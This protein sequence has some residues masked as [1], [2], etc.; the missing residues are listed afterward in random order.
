MSALPEYLQ[1]LLRPDAYPHPVDS[2]ELIETHVSWVLLTGEFAYKI[3]RPVHYGFIDLR[4]PERRAFLCQE[5]LRL[6]RRFAPD[7]YLDVRPICVFDGAA[8]LTGRGQVVEQAVRMRQF[9]RADE[10]DRLLEGD[11]IVPAELAVFGVELARLHAGLPVTGAD[12]NPG[13]ASAVRAR[14]LDNAAEC[15]RAEQP[16]GGPPGWLSDLERRLLEELN[17][18]QA[19]LGRRLLAGRVRECHGDLHARNIVRLGGH[20]RAFDCLEFDPAL[21]WLDVADEIAFL[22]ADLDAR[23]R[24]QHAQAFLGGYLE[25]S[26]DHEACTLLPLFKVHRALVRAKVAALAGNPQ[27]SAAYLECVRRCLTAPLP[28]LVLMCGLSGA[29]KSWLAQGLAAPLSAVLLRSD[30]ERRRLA[31]SG[32]LAAG[33]PGIATGHYAPEVTAQVYRH[34]LK[35]ARECLSGGFTTIVDAT[36]RQRADRL[37]FRD[38]ATSLGVNSCV[39]HC[40]APREVLEARIRERRR[41]ND[42]PSE[43]DLSVLA[44]QEAHFET[45]QAG[46]AGAVLSADTADSASVETLL[47]EIGALPRP[48]VSDPDHC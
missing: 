25:A 12:Q 13:W 37:A 17:R 35:C 7:L 46:E 30:V 38:L 2:M 10:L 27:G 31:A 22:L 18:A 47:Q 41:R 33:D 20:L 5:E 48:Q 14:V 45:P 21:R 9:T 6:N 32:T 40:R 42:D 11:R 43:A 16:G 19:L 26:G 44:W 3:K 34:L 24:P 4:S 15:A 1:A 23:G 8:N 36:F 28:V 39:V 29:G